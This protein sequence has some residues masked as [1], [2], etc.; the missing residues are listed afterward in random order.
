[1]ILYFNPGHEVAVSN[2][3]PYYMAP[4]NVLRMQQDLSFLP[5][6]YSSPG[7]SVFI[8]NPVEKKEHYSF[9]KNHFKQL[10]AIVCP[11][12][13]HSLPYDEV[14]FWG[15]S[16]QVINH[17]SGINNE[18]KLQ[19]QIPKWN[20]RYKY[21]NS[22]IAARD[23]LTELRKNISGISDKIIPNF[24][25]TIEEIE[26][27]VKHADSPLLA[28][29]PYSS[30]GRGLLWLLKPYVDSKEKE[31]LHGILKKQQQVSVEYVLDKDTDFAM[32]F[33]CD[34][35][36]EVHFEGY[37]LFETNQKG[38]YSANYLLSQDK[39]LSILTKKTPL[40]LLETV[41]QNICSLLKPIAV[42]YKG[43]IG[44]DMM[45]YQEN[46]KYMLHPCLEINMRYNMGYLALRL[47][48]NY[49]AP[50]ANGKFIIDFN[51]QEQKILFLHTEMQ[52][53]H[54][55]YF[56]NEKICSG[57]LSLCPVTLESKYNAYIVI[58]EK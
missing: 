6:W 24:Y 36:G 5:A 46:G 21:L 22:R 32:Q 44:I 30:S 45:I 20:D 18:L 34:G 17:F 38:G 39:I 31:I 29:A 35:D 3:S 23:F 56:E 54:P 47:Q 16:P 7:D 12:T 8:D 40:Q 53:K 42:F 14:L 1:M 57:Y 13:I 19:L 10:P 15:I 4:T 51:A 2:M 41:K 33:L 49:L 55:L 28:K 50:E 27:A 25:S 9:L 48:Q 26:E 52:K 11:K 58:N 37:S 43:C